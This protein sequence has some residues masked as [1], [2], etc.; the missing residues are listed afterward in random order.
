MF[1]VFQQFTLSL[2]ILPSLLH[3]TLTLIVLFL[4]PTHS[5][6]PEMAFTINQTNFPDAVLYNTD[7]FVVKS[8]RRI[9][10]TGFA[11]AMDIAMAD[12]MYGP[13]GTSH[14]PIYVETPTLSLSGIFQGPES[15][16]MSPRYTIR[17]MA[18]DNLWLSTVMNNISAMA[19]EKISKSLIADP[20][21]CPR[22]CLPML[23]DADINLDT[24]LK[25]FF[26][27]GY[28]SHFL[29]LNPDCPIWNYESME[30]G[31]QEINKM[32]S[33]PSHGQYR[34]RLR[35]Y[36]LYV[37]P[38]GSGN[39]QV[40]SLSVKVVQVLY[41]ATDTSDKSKLAI[42]ISQFE[43]DIKGTT[44]LEQQEEGSTTSFTDLLNNAGS[45]ASNLP[46]PSSLT[47]TKEKTKIPRRKEK[48]TSPNLKRL[49]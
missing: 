37:G 2:Y 11:A 22:I 4:L 30:D 19:F 5:L 7:D 9:T 25:K 46:S 39:K 35:V 18:N 17:I 20:K 47:K 43:N 41:K 49:V 26:I 10:R 32:V 1:K 8:P 31:S 42:D 23:Q 38:H 28:G 14:L 48:T 34:L 21:Q 29:K 40:F 6:F 24:Y 33:L 13:Q 27:P 45:T 44:Q 16:G 12:L 3:Q 15:S 36:G